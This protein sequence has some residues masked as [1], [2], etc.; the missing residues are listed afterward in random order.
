[1]VVRDLIFTTAETH[2][3]VLGGAANTARP[4]TGAHDRPRRCVLESIGGAAIV[5]FSAQALEMPTPNFQPGNAYVIAGGVQV[6][7]IGPKQV[8]YGVG[9]AGPVR[10]SVSANDSLMAFWKPHDNRPQP[11]LQT[12][13]STAQVFPERRVPI[14]Q[15]GLR[16]KR[17]VMTYF[18]DPLNPSELRVS[19]AD[20]AQA[21]EYTFDPANIGPR[22][23]VLAPR[24]Q[25]YARRVG[26]SA[27]P[28]QVVSTAVS[29]IPYGAMA[30][31]TGIPGPDGQE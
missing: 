13:F 27:S 10:L 24:Q 8:L 19:L 16:P 5:A 3:L 22:V 6:V 14:S 21:H 25:L 9:L 23:F 4:L 7:P 12:D 2:A 29:E 30:G 1:M 26:G 20:G 28:A 17:V 31:P 15:L 11:M 18:P